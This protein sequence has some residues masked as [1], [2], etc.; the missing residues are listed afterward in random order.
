LIMYPAFSASPL[1]RCS[2]FNNTLSSTAS[3]FNGWRP[4]SP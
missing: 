1:H 3:F 4:S 2:S